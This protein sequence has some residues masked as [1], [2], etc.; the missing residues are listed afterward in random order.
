[1]LDGLGG[2]LDCV[3]LDAMIGFDL[4]SWGCWRV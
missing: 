2:L 3:G 1:M 4:D